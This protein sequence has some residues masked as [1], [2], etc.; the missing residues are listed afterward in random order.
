MNPESH[1]LTGFNRSQNRAP[2]RRLSLIFHIL[3]TA[4]LRMLTLLVVLLLTLPVAVLPIGSGVPA[5]VWIILLFRSHWTL[6]A[7]G[8]TLIGM[9]LVILVATVASQMYAATPPITGAD[10]KP[11][12]GSI[13]T[14]EEITLNGSRQWITIRVQDATKPILLN[15]GMGGPGGGGFATRSLF[16]PLE[17]DYV[18]V[19]WDEPGTGKSYDAV[20]ISSLTP[21]RFIEDAHALTLYLRERFHQE[22]SSFTAHPGRASWASGWCS[23]TL[24]CSTPT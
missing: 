17:K 13:A 1:F 16:E 21:E 5:P 22:K 11:L 15:L 2:A 18:V 10:G 12:P 4:L 7:V 24:T 20:P 23:A 9:V 3:S 14:L 8:T 6:S 19:G